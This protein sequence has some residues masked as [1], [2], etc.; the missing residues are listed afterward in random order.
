MSQFVIVG[1]KK[2]DEKK[3]RKK[4]ITIIFKPDLSG[5]LRKTNLNHVILNVTNK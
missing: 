3:E 2:T 1:G 4:F 5:F